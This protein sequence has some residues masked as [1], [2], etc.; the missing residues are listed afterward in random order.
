MSP[1]VLSTRLLVL[2]GTIALVA[3]ITS[4]AS[5]GISQASG[6]RLHGDPKTIADLDAR[7]G[8]KAPNAHQTA[9]ARGK[10][11]RWNRFGRRRC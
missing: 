3:A 11:V 1:K 4:P 9:L 5:G 2:V 7:K 6:P 10:T 8:L